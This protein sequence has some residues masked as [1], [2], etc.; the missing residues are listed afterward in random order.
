MFFPLNN[1]NNDR[2]FWYIT[3][4]MH[5]IPAPTLDGFSSVTYLPVCEELDRYRIK[6]II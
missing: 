1:I 4:E 6:L 5:H 3:K 2:T